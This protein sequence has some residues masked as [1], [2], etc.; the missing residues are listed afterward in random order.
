MLFHDLTRCGLGPYIPRFLSWGYS[1]V[2][3]ALQWH[4]KGQ[5][6]DSAYL[7]HFHRWSKSLDDMTLVPSAFEPVLTIAH[8][9]IGPVFVG[10]LS[11]EQLLDQ[12]LAAKIQLNDWAKVLFQ[13]D[14]FITSAVRRP[15]ELLETTVGDLGFPPGATMPEIHAKALALG[16]SL[17][18]LE[19]APH[20]RLQYRDQTEECAVDQTTT[21]RAPPGSLTVASLPVSDDP[22]FPKGFYLR[23]VESTLW[24]RGWSTFSL[25]GIASFSVPHSGIH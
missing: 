17:P 11:K 5:R 21:N 16:L 7:H 18:P 3:R 14:L 13:S 4:C 2:G 9:R 20:L 25:P 23:R 12:L 1:S 10:G 15:L 22:E 6:F 8:R 24:L 19:L